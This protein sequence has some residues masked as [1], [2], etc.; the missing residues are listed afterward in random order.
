LPEVSAEDEL[1]V[2]TFPAPILEKIIELPDVH[3]L[4]REGSARSL[5][6]QPISGRCWV[7]MESGLLV[8]LTAS[9]EAADHDLFDPT[10]LRSIRAVVDEPG[11]RRLIADGGP[12]GA[13]LRL[14]AA[15]EIIDTFRLAF[16]LERP[17]TLTGLARSPDHIY[18][19]DER[20]VILGMNLEGDVLDR[21]GAS[22]LEG[23]RPRGLYYEA[24]TDSLLVGLP[25][26]V[27]QWPFPLS[28]DL[29]A[30]NL[31]GSAH[32]PSNDPT[33]H[34][35][36]AHLVPD[37]ISGG[38]FNAARAVFSSR[39]GLLAF[40]NPAWRTTAIASLGFDPPAGFQPFAMLPAD[41]E[42]NLWR[43]YG[44]GDGQAELAILQ[45]PINA[46]APVWTLYP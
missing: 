43:L 2:G 42:A 6:I 26:R 16:A 20:G 28:G 7:L 38:G 25:G 9:Q 5:A 24:R 46:A 23:R 17:V 39:Q 36:A 4:L 45:Q 32:E 3:D 12:L 34:P 13:V 11:G 22:L 18:A 10:L 15:G 1:P 35:I 37:S 14:N 31:S 29:F 30:D 40:L 44:D 33:Q 21:F 8:R 19:L 41:P 27:L